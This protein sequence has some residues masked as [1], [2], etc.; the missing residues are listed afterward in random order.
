MFARLSSILS[1]DNYHL[2]K[3]YDEVTSR[4]APVLPND[5]HVLTMFFALQRAADRVY[6]A[7]G[8]TP[9][10]KANI[11]SIGYDEFLQF[12]DLHSGYMRRAA[13]LG[14]VNNFEFLDNLAYHIF[15]ETA[16][17][18]LALFASPDGAM[19]LVPES[20]HGTWGGLTLGYISLFMSICG[21]QTMNQEKV[22]ELMSSPGQQRM[23]TDIDIIV[24]GNPMALTS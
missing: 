17:T 13:Q 4:F 7:N 19:T 16:D 9:I 11:K 12:M 2:R 6:Y 20:L 24:Q 21:S 15:P 14:F 1:G 3:L 23:Q 22:N 8:K 10:I 5:P 18:S